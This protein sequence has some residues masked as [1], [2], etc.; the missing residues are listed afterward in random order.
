[1]RPAKSGLLQLPV[2]WRSGAGR[3][4]RQLGE[5]FLLLRKAI[6]GMFGKDHFAVNGHIENPTFS[7]DE[8]RFDA[9]LFF[10]AFRQTGGAG[11]IVSLSA[12]GNRH[13]HGC[14]LVFRVEESSQKHRCN[15]QFATLR[16][17][18]L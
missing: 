7:F 10:D 8:L 17:N 11:K 2:L 14:T 6:D 16:R 9:G 5:D 12:V 3:T 1:M 15:F 4:G 18:A 13:L